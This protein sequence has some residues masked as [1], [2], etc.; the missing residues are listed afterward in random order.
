MQITLEVVERSGVFSSLLG[1]SSL[2][3]VGTA[4]SRVL[5]PFLH[6]HVRP[7]SASLG[8]MW[9]NKSAISTSMFSLPSDENPVGTEN[10]T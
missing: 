7:S 1:T 9:M 2:A 10:K 4:P 8:N 5:V 6:L 3:D